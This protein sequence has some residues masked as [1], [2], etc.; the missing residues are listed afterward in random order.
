MDLVRDLQRCRGP[1][2]KFAPVADPLRRS[3]LFSTTAV[4][5]VR[6][7]FQVQKL[8]L[9]SLT[10]GSQLLLCEV[11]VEFLERLR[12]GG[13]HHL[14]VVHV[15]IADRTNAE[16]VRVARLAWVQHDALLA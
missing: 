15:E 6:T 14:N 16:R 11:D 9:L 12:D 13:N 1:S 4:A 8:R 2:L 5:L 10:A 7:V 3:L